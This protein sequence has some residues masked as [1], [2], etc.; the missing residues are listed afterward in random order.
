MTA[1]REILIGEVMARLASVPGDPLVLRQPN[2]QPSTYPALTIDDRGQRRIT[3]GAIHN[4]YAITLVIGGYVAGQ[5]AAGAAALNALYA[6]TIRAL[7]ADG[8]QLGGLADVITEGDLTIE[9]AALDRQFT[10]FFELIL[11]VQ[12]RSRTHDPDL[13]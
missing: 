11:D 7:F 1:R 8:A 4:I 6:A 5:G 2:A 13:L 3:A 10:T 9:G 12:F